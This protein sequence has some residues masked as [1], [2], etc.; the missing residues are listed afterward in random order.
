MS[1]EVEWT[2]EAWTESRALSAPARRPLMDAAAALARRAEIAARNRRSVA[3]RLGEQ[4]E[5]IWEMRARGHRLLYCVT[6][7]EPRDG[8]RC[9]RILRVVIGCPPGPLVLPTEA[10]RELERRRRTLRKL[11]GGIAHELVR[12]AWL[13]EL[14]RERR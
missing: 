9:A 4:P 1:F 14:T 2:S 12:R 3:G 11:G 10:T 8:R 13:A 6:G 5:P 7:P